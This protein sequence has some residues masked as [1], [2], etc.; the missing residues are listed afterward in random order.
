ML[1]EEKKEGGSPRARGNTAGLATTWEKEGAKLAE[2][3]RLV[4]KI[5]GLEKK[6][7]SLSP[8]SKPRVS[9]L[10]KGIVSRRGGGRSKE[11]RHE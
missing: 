1:E 3:G 10:Q 8:K 5:R 6:G 2:S 4:E 11:P 9:F 7:V